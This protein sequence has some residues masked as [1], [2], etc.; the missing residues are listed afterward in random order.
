M[1]KI[2]SVTI[3][4]ALILATAVSAQQGSTGSISG[5]VADPSGQVVPNA[6]VKLISE[7]NG[8]SRT[9]TTNETGDFFFGAVAPGAYTV[10]V[11]A[12]GFRPIEQKENMVLGS[13][14]LAIGTLKLEVGSVNESISVTAQGAAVATTTTAQATTI[15]S[16]MMDLIAIKGRDPMSVFKTLPGVQIIGDQDTWGGSYQSTVPTFQGRGGNTVYT[17][18]VNGGDGGGGGNFS[19]ITSIDAI[20]EVNIQANSYT[21][22]YGC[23][24]GAQV[25]MITKHGGQ[26]FHGTAAYYKRHEQFNAQNFFNNRAGTNPLTGA[27]NAPKPRYRY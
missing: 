17:D 5:T 12:T 10:R 18:G 24:G 22:E 4:L 8:E 3:A 6:S 16:K 15:D 19:G 27:P 21:A 1:S 26:Q 23:K 25:N 2:V 9:G 7:L 20:A 11:E 13:G 14:R